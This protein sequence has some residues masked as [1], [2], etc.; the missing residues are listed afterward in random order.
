MFHLPRAFMKWMDSKSIPF[1]VVGKHDSLFP[2]IFKN[3][4]Y[5]K[6]YIKYLGRGAVATDSPAFLVT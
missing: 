4:V 6:T 5:I 2:Y 3:T 1:S